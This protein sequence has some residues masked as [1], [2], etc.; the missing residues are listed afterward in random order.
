MGQLTKSRITDGMSFGGTGALEGLAT[1]TRCPDIP[2]KGVVFKAQPGNT[3]SAWIGKPT[4]VTVGQGTTNATD[5]FPLAASEQTGF[6][7]CR[8]LNEFAYV[9]DNDGD[10]ISYT[11][12]T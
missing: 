9:C 2:C 5:G 10:D 8:N 6:W 11:Y 4:L 7:P 1:R 12:W 3:G